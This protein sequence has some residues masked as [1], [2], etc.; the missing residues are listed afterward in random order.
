MG[1]DIVMHLHHFCNGLNHVN[2]MRFNPN[3]KHRNY[4]GNVAMREFG[5]VLSRW[6]EDHAL[7]VEARNYRLQLELQLSMKR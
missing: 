5:Y 4:Y 2:R 3:S 1:A 6:P 7:A